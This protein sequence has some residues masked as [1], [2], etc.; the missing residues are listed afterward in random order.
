MLSQLKALLLFVCAFCLSTIAS[1]MY[2]WNKTD[3]LLPS[4]QYSDPVAA[5]NDNSSSCYNDLMPDMWQKPRG[6]FAGT[7][8]EILVK[9]P[10]FNQ[11]DREVTN[12]K[13]HIINWPLKGDKNKQE[14]SGES[15]NNKKMLDQTVDPL[16]R[17]ADKNQSGKKS[18][19]EQPPD[20]DRVY[21]T[22]IGEGDYCY[23]QGCN[24]ERCR[25]SLCT[26]MDQEEVPLAKKTKYKICS[27]GDEYYEKNVV[28]LLSQR[29][30]GGEQISTRWL[31]GFS[32]RRLQSNS[33]NPERTYQHY[34]EDSQWSSIL[35]VLNDGR[36]AMS[37]ES[38]GE[39]R[40]WSPMMPLPYGHS[41][42]DLL[43]SSD[44]SCQSLFKRFGSALA[45]N[46]VI[47]NIIYYA[48]TDTARVIPESYISRLL[49]HTARVLG[50]ITLRDGRLL[51]WSKDQTVRV[52]S[53]L[54]N[55]EWSSVSFTTNIHLNSTVQEL[56]DG[57]L[58][59]Y[60]Y[61]N[62]Q[63][64]IWAE[65]ESDKQ[66]TPIVTIDGLV[67]KMRDGRLLS[68]SA[69]DL[70]IWT[71]CNIGWCPSD[72]IGHFET[73]VACGA[74]HDGR[75][76]RVTL[77]GG[78]SNLHCHLRIWKESNGKWLSTLIAAGRECD[79]IYEI[80]ALDNNKFLV[81][82]RH[83]RHHYSLQVWEEMEDV[84][85]SSTI[86]TSERPSFQ[87]VILNS[88]QILTFGDSG[89]KHDPAAVIW[90]QHNNLW[91][92]ETLVDNG[93]VIRF[94]H[95]FLLKD[96][97]WVSWNSAGEFRLWS[98]YQHQGV[99]TS[100]VLL[101]AERNHSACTVVELPGGWLMMVSKTERVNTL[102]IWNL[103]PT[104][105]NE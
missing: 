29:Q 18:D 53:E 83:D 17:D 102:R 25:C 41:N 87:P 30:I 6:G 52:W 57:S 56:K 4:R 86:L 82:M 50:A 64:T 39:L 75:I 49:G 46:P 28:Q 45:I 59:S 103:F 55:G 78:Y 98:D 58:M 71:K 70:I 22:H 93:E 12:Q 26:G 24:G 9:L 33:R 34:T 10:L 20:K 67:R 1:N 38:S 13:F 94:D 81:L 54:D 100:C 97:R 42:I 37:W 74:L 65:R 31:S 35:T 27:S 85:L 62:D 5:E 88:G 69:N 51:T 99:W 60:D 96:G 23:A 8:G 63:R 73:F 47:S 90:T 43:S 40:V 7:L 72:P 3:I 84:W 61:D 11:M 14:I 89:K 68:R 19:E 79:Y 104:Q 48:G 105:P 101:E 15:D 92:S 44:I 66:W 77:E 32:Q 36:V 80:M 21:H 95:V 91:L 16:A 76:V 2:A